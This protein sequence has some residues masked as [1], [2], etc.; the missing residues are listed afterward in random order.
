MT[1]AMSAKMVR[2]MVISK[3]EKTGFALMRDHACGMQEF[4]RAI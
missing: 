4:T 3:T 1:M 2:F